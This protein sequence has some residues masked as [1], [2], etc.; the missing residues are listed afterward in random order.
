MHLDNQH[1]V[2]DNDDNK[3]GNNRSGD[4]K[5]DADEIT[6]QGTLMLDAT[7]APSDIRYPQP[8]Q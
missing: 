1:K 2:D 4:D 6:N 5:N 3:P 8:S 7:C